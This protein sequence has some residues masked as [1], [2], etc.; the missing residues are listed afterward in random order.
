MSIPEKALKTGVLTLYSDTATLEIIREVY[1]HNEKMAECRMKMKQIEEIEMGFAVMN[2]LVTAC[3]T[4]AD[5]KVLLTKNPTLVL[6]CFIVFA[7]LYVY[8]VLAKK[9]LLKGTLSVIVLLYINYKFLIIIAA[10]FVLYFMR[11][12][13]VSK[14]Q[15]IKGYPIFPDIRIIHERGKAPKGTE[16]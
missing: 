8:F 2:G 16:E 10:D 9:D 6:I 7:A 4:L 11:R 3:L 15:E 13:I 14:L 5:R 12:N 1:A